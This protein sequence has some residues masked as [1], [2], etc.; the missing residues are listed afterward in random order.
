M[1]H[2]KISDTAEVTF[3]KGSSE[4]QNGEILKVDYW[5]SLTIE[6]LGSS[7]NTARTVSFYRKSR[8][9][10]LRAIMGVRTSDFTTAISTTGVN[11][12]WQFDLTGGYEI[13]MDLTAI[14]GG[15]VSVIGTV[16]S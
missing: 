14:T 11:E 1:T 6:I 4:A 5:K 2:I 13:V 15:V 3:H 9:G 7:A 8:D 10:T 16:V 12:E